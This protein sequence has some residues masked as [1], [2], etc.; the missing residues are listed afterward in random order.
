MPG[1]LAVPKFPTVSLFMNLSHLTF[2]DCKSVKSM[3]VR[4][5]YHLS[6]QHDADT[7]IMFLCQDFQYFRI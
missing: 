7:L 4:L 2:T 6:F 1:P 3:F 5:L